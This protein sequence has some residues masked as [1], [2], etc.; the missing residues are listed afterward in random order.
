MKTILELWDRPDATW[1]FEKKPGCSHNRRLTRVILGQS[2]DEVYYAKK[3][4]DCG[5]LLYA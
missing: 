5:G 2:N 3:C 4:A 1:H